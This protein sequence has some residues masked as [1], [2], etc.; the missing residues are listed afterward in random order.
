MDE[1]LACMLV[2]LWVDE[3]VDERVYSSVDEWVV[4]L[5]A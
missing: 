4:P 3:L 5:A 1:R 2:E